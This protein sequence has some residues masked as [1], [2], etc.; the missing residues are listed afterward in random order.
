MECS[1]RK[2]AVSA[3]R[4]PFIL[5]C[6]K[7]LLFELRVTVRHPEGRGDMGSA[8]QEASASHDTLAMVTELARHSAL[9]GLLLG[10]VYT[11]PDPV[12]T[13]LPEG[14]Q[15]QRGCFA[16]LSPGP[17]CLTQGAPRMIG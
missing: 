12:F 8:L 13:A 1:R 7:Q 15:Q 10:G 9:Q 6:H 5:P 16:S 11:V 14:L 3:P 17:A 4:A 2:V